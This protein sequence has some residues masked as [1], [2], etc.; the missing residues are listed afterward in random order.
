MFAASLPQ[1][2]LEWIEF[3]WPG[4]FLALQ[5]VLSAQ[6]LA[7]GVSGKPGQACDRPNRVPLPVQVADVRKL[8]H[9]DHGDASA[10]SHG[11]RSRP[12]KT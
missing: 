11:R 10:K 2:V 9:S 4:R 3:R 7:G 5:I 6:G 1:V 8:I 12:G